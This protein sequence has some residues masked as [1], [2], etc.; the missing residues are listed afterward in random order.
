MRIVTSRH[1]N[2]RILYDA[3]RAPQ[4]GP[5]WFTPEFWHQKAQVTGEAPGRG[6]SVFIEAAPN[7]HWVLRPYRRGGLIGRFNDDRY[8][9]LGAERSR[10]FR[11]FRLTARLRNAGLPV[12]AP[13]GGCLWPKGCT[14]QAALITVG[15]PEARPLADVLPT[16]AATPQLLSRVGAMIRQFHE[17][18]L[19]HVDL[20]AR[21]ILL[22]AVDSPWLIDLDRCRIRGKGGF[23]KRNL[24][25]LK[26]SFDKFAPDR[27][28]RHHTALLSGYN[29]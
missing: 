13:V 17:L 16:E 2:T 1:A 27:A 23:K 14:Y 10:A 5:D 7:E 8:A 21:N 15:I 9:W 20:N 6:A 24:E 11:E 18:G 29:A 3:E 25:R 4:I 26:R 22:D 12:P 28:R 19:D